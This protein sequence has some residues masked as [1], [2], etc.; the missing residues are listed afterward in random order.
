MRKGVWGV[1]GVRNPPS[2]VS[3]GGIET[4][5]RGFGVTEIFLEVTASRPGSRGLSAVAGERWWDKETG[6]W[7]WAGLV[8]WIS[9]SFAVNVLKRT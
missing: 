3:V 2:P 8:F 7:L 5:A 6:A 9:Y 4:G 1:R